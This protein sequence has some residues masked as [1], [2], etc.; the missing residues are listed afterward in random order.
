LAPAV[1]A[2]D[3]EMFTIHS[4]LFFSRSYVEAARSYT[5]YDR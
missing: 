5:A 4:L 1:A 3:F 2:R